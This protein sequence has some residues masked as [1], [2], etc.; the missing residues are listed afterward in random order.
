MHCHFA[1]FLPSRGFI[2]SGV[3]VLEKASSEHGCPCLVHLKFNRCH[4]RCSSVCTMTDSQIGAW[5]SRSR[6]AY[7]LAPR[8]SRCALSLPICIERFN[9][10]A[11]IARPV[12]VYC[13]HRLLSL[14]FATTCLIRALCPTPHLNRY[15]PRLIHHPTI[16]AADPSTSLESRAGRLGAV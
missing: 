3:P 13:A 5:L 2:I 12:S 9:A 7:V 11:A 10:E 15:R 14:P 16:H 1:M 4:Q 6:V 8:G